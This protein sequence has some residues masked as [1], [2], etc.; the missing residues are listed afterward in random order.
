MPQLGCHA[1]ISSAM[2]MLVK[3]LLR[4]IYGLVHMVSEDLIFVSAH[5]LLAN[6]MWIP[7][8]CLSPDSEMCIEAQKLCPAT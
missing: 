2:S 3:S 4:H 6:K 7:C 8:H 1:I 5:S